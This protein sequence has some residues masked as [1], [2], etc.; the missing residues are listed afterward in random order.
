MGGV[1]TTKIGDCDVKRCTMCD[2]FIYSLER[3]MGRVNC[4]DAE[5]GEFAY[6]RERLEGAKEFWAS[7]WAFN[8]MV[9][10]LDDTGTTHVLECGPE[11]KVIA[12]NTLDD[13]FWS[14]TAVSDGILVFRGVDYI[15][16]IGAAE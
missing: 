5:T 3:R 2:G 11:F 8:N 16:G 7:P 6:R 9:F 10:C 12:T 15:Y 4:I 1:D 14:S 13:R